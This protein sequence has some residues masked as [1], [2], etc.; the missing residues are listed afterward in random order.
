MLAVRYAAFQQPPEVRS[1]PEPDC[2]ADG[3]IVEVEATGL[4]RSD[5][6]GW[7]G[8]DPDIALPHVPG[9]EF[10]GRI[11]AVGAEVTSFGTGQRATAA[12]IGACGRCASCRR[13][14]PQVCDDS[15]ISCSLSRGIDLSSL[16]GCAVIRCACARWHGS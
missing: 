10:A 6:H 11:V 8:H 7:M 5:W 12:F 15:F 14:E 4:C 16:R 1:V 13:G 2:P 3:V 9:H